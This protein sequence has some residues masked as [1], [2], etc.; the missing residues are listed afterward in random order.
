MVQVN[1]LHCNL[2]ISAV[3]EPKYKSTVR[4]DFLSLFS[5]KATVDN[6]VKEGVKEHVAQNIQFSPR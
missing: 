6:M 5:H 3:S 1:S 4:P 2:M